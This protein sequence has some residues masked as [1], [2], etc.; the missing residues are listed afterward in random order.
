MGFKRSGS[1]SLRI[2][3]LSENNETHQFRTT[4]IRF[5]KRTTKCRGFER[6]L[7]SIS[8]VPELR[9]MLLFKNPP[10]DKRFSFYARRAT[11]A[12]RLFLDC[13]ARH[14]VLGFD[15]LVVLLELGLGLFSAPAGQLRVVLLQ[16]RYL[17]LTDAQVEL[18][19]H[20]KTTKHASQGN[21]WLALASC[22]CYLEGAGEPERRGMFTRAGC[23]D[24][25]S[26]RTHNFCPSM[27]TLVMVDRLVAF[28]QVDSKNTVCLAPRFLLTLRFIMT[29]LD[30]GILRRPFRKPLHISSHIRADIGFS[31]KMLAAPCQKRVLIPS[32]WSARMHTNLNA[33]FPLLR[34]LLDQARVF[35][36]HCDQFLVLVSQRL[37]KS[38]AYMPTTVAL[39]EGRWGPGGWLRVGAT[40]R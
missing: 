39:V 40:T 5:W 7:L 21:Q 27:F 4:Y 8:T 16:G 15:A 17:V 20:V 25:P 2:L 9:L 10:T 6:S 30:S 33:R 19:L 13:P 28:V 26:S 35:L 12:K 24:A 31:R 22:M 14:L 37:L 3:V 18:R 32:Y 34:A 29:D 23:T 11:L 38:T 36:L 1:G